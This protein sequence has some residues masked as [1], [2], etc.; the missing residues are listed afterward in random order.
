MGIANVANIFDP[1][2][3]ILGGG[4]IEGFYHFESFSSAFQNQFNK[5]VLDACSNVRILPAAL[6]GFIERD[7]HSLIK[8]FLSAAGLWR[9]PEPRPPPPEPFAAPEVSEPVLDYPKCRIILRKSGWLEYKPSA[10][11]IIMSSSHKIA[12]ECLA[13]KYGHT[14]CIAQTCFSPQIKD[15]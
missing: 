11:R 6:V 3:I 9:E 7:N 15:I 13:C 8:L 2:A 4:I 14:D 10:Q 12:S 1:Q 5:C